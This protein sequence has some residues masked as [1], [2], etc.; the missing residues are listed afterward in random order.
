MLMAEKEVLLQRLA[1]LGVHA[2]PSTT[3]YFVAAVPCPELEGTRDAF[4]LC[5]DAGIKTV[6]VSDF[7]GLG[8]SSNLL[9]IACQLPHANQRFLDAL[10]DVVEP[11]REKGPRRPLAYDAARTLDGARSSTAMVDG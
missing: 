9:R 10:A 7:D 6:R 3:S 4:E 8:R 1:R 2:I 5:L 11:L